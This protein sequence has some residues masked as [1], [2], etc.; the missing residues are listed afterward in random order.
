MHLFNIVG[1]LLVFTFSFSTI[2]SYEA[3]ELNAHSWWQGQQYREELLL[4][5]NN[6]T[7]TNLPDYYIKRIIAVKAVRNCAQL[8]DELNC[9]G[10]SIQISWFSP[11][12]EDL[13]VWNFNNKT[14]SVMA[15][16]D[17]CVPDVGSSVAVNNDEVIQIKLHSESFYKGK[18]YSVNVQ[19]CTHLKESLMLSSQIGSITVPSNQCVLAFVMDGENLDVP[20]VGTGTDADC[21]VGIKK[22][23]VVEFRDGMPALDNLQSWGAFHKPK[24]LIALSPCQCNHSENTI[25]TTP[26]EETSSLSTKSG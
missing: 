6:K 8:Y 7:C 1:V 10:N 17:P 3:I 13:G 5:I 23:N 4:S 11:S 12:P 18:L 2:R 14:E 19:G 16:Q 9:H 24:F 22:L 20:P 26:I 15:C 25:T 21:V